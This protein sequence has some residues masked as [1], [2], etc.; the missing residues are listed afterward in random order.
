MV[1][2]NCCEEID[3]EET[4]SETEVIPEDKLLESRVEELESSLKRTMADFDNYRKRIVKE[5]QR[6]LALAGENIIRD[7]LPVLDDLERVLDDESID[8]E[9]LSLIHRK[10][11]NTLGDHGLETIEAQGSEFNPYDHECIISE[12]VEDEEKH[13]IVLE[14]L[15]KGYRLNSNVIRPAKVKV[16]K[17]VKEEEVE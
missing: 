13:D 14:E 15:Q 5:R 9:G 3:E 1:E 11:K 17:Y 12:E 10:F 6:L 2:E 8:N 7:L 16:G 4:P